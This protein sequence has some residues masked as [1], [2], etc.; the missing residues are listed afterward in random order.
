MISFFVKHKKSI[1]I[2]TLF[3]FLGSIAYLGLSAY[4]RT[5]YSLDAAQVGKET[6]SYRQLDKVSDRQA[7]FL[8]NQGLDVD[9]QMMDFIRQQTLSGL[10]AVELLSQA[11]QQAGMFVSDYEVAYDIKTSPLFAPNGQFDKNQYTYA[12]RQLFQ[13]SPAEYE[14]Q[15]RRETLANRFR[16]M[17]NSMYKLTPE[18]IKTSYQVQ[19]G[20]LKDFDANKPGFKTALL[21][22]K[23]ETAPDAFFQS[24]TEKVNVKTFLK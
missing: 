12:L 11:A 23:L 10:I 20:S 7:N 19:Q 2:V 17:L 15:F 14:Q 5:S 8:R 13:I 6:I 24:F 4:S 1:L 18:E 16:H 3:F 9:E 21:E 22:T